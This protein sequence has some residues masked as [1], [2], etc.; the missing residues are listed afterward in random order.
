[1]AAAAQKIDWQTDILPTETLKALNWLAKQSWLKKTD[2][3][4]A[5]GTALA[6][7][8]GHR[9]SVDLDFFTPQTD[10]SVKPLL[11]QLA[12][13]LWQTTLTEPGTLYGQLFGAK[14]SFLANAGFK[15]ALPFLSYGQVQVAQAQDI[16][17]SK[18]VAI[19][20]RGR[21]RD[22][23]DLYWCANNLLPLEAMMPRL[24]KQYPL[25]EFNYHHLLKSLV[26][27]ADA[28]NEPA[29]KIF[30]SASWPEVKNFFKKEAD[31]LA[32]QFLNLKS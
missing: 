1:M 2:W 16:A 22:F 5:G 23:F 20:Q 7:Q 12:K 19:S 17:V 30:F 29:P 18:L 10:F 26:Y 8:A 14:V 3:Y 11:N 13:T 25:A 32:A 21:Q 15:P 27:F 24:K 28:E 31:Q 9:Q 4:L 6:L